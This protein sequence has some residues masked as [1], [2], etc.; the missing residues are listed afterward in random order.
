MCLCGLLGLGLSGLHNVSQLQFERKGI[1]GET[2]REREGAGGGWESE[3]H[4][5]DPS[6]LLLQEHQLEPLE[7]ARRP[8]HLNRLPPDRP[9][10]LLPLG[11]NITLLEHLADDGRAGGAGELLEHEGGE[12]EAAEGEGLA[13]DSGEG[14]FDQGLQSI[15]QY[16][17]NSTLHALH[18]LRPLL[19][20][21]YSFPLPSKLC[22][23]SHS[24][25]CGQ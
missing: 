14:S 9:R 21:S 2:S 23:N 16:T 1:A 10:A 11:Q 5:H 18:L 24:P 7:I 17:H 22:R 20:H 3:T 25:C 4:L 12:H 6:P 13:G 8:P 19:D 15:R